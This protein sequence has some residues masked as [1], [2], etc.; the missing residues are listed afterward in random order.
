[1]LL[2]RLLSHLSSQ[3]DKAGRIPGAIEAHNLFS[4]KPRQLSSSQQV[5]S[6]NKIKMSAKTE[7]Q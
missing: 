4:D 6:D 3:L 5:S 7:R 2:F 1:M